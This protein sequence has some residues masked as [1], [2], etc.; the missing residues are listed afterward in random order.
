MTQ[1]FGVRKP[2]QR[3]MSIAPAVLA[4]LWVGM[5]IAMRGDPDMP[6]LCLTLVAAAVMVVVVSFGIEWLFRYRVVVGD[7]GICIRFG[8]RSID[9]GS[10]KQ[11]RCGQYEREIRRLGLVWGL[12]SIPI[13]HVWVAVEGSTGTQLLFTTTRGML[14]RKLDWPIALPPRIAQVF[15]G[16]AVRLRDALGA[17]IK[18]G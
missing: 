17:Q 3:L 12:V 6:R 7:D 15:S 11:L 13:T 5:A 2:S 10:P 1:V 16:N 4:A 18:A 14:R 8:A 9:F